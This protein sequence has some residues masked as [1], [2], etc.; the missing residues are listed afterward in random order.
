VWCHQFLKDCSL[1]KNV[2]LVHCPL[3]RHVI[4]GVEITCYDLS[5][6]FLQ[7]V[8]KDDRPDFVVIDG[9][10]AEPGARFGILPLVRQ[11]L[12]PR[13]WFFMD[14]ALRDGELRAAQLLS[15]LP[16]VRVDGV[17]LVGKGLLVGQVGE[18]TDDSVSHPQH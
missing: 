17:Y 5:D 9:P 12:R 3:R 14:D 1:E 10:A 7:A 15:Q 11:F 16:Y 2:R 6:G 13:A 4:E 18:G 8:L